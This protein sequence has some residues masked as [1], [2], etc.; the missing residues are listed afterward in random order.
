MFRL[1]KK[2]KLCSDVAIAKLFDR[3]ADDHRSALAYPLRAV[4]RVNDARAVT[5]PRFLITIPKRKIRHA[6]DRVLLRRRVREAYRLAHQS[7]L[8]TQM[9]VDIAFGYVANGISD[10]A[11]IERAMNRLLKKIADP[12]AVATTGDTAN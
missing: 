3:E 6:V 5:C 11:A 8:P 10:Y 12:H 9:P 7:Y 4:W 2:Q 1:Y